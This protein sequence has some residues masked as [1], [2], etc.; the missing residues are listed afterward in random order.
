MEAPRTPAQEALHIALHCLYAKLHCTTKPPPQPP[1]A[2]EVVGRRAPRAPAAGGR[3]KR[4]RAP[5][6]SRP[7]GAHAARTLA[8]G[9]RGGGCRARSPTLRQTNNATF[10]QSMGRSA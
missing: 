2:W 9:A 8:P 3:S 5:A 6:A 10:V 1:L 7:E 4:A